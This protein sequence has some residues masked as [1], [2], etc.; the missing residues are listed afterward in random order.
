MNPERSDVNT[1][2]HDDTTIIT[3]I[4]ITGRI[5]GNIAFCIL[6]PSAQ[7]IVEKML[8]ME[9]EPGSSD[10]IDGIGELVNMI[11]GGTKTL[12]NDTECK[13]EISIPN[14]IRGNQLRSAQSVKDTLVEQNYVYEDIN[15][16]VKFNYRLK[17]EAEDGKDEQK[18]EKQQ[19][20][21]NAMDKL[22]QLI[23]DNGA[24]PG[25]RKSKH[26]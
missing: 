2:P 23:D 11:A 13:F 24:E 19:S 21:G 4:G 14:T 17:E 10:I 3:S 1:F 16:T 18:A 12:L 6:E 25:N 20:A 22:S 9:L 5:T 15:F 8:E 7:K 26:T